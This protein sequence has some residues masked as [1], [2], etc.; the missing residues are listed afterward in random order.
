MPT[1]IAFHVL[2]ELD[3]GR[4]EALLRRAEADLSEY[5][6]A[7]TPI[8]EAVRE[9]GDVALRRYANEFD[10][11]D[12]S[13]TGLLVSSEEFDRAAEDVSPELA[14][15]L[16][17]AASNIRKFCSMQMPK[18]SRWETEMA[19]GVLVG[20]RLL[21]VD[22]AACYCPSGKG[23]FP[24]VALM[25]T[26]PALM[27]GVPEIVLLTPPGPDG[28]VDAGTLVAAR[29]AGVSKV[30]K[31]GGA[32]AVAAAAFGTES[33]PKCVKFEGPGN[34]W[35][36][37]ARR[38]LS[39]TIESRLPA[40]PS[41]T[42]LLADPSADPRLCALDL[43]IESEHGP[44]S[45]AFLVTWSAEV[46]RAARDAIPGFLANMGEQRRGYCESVLSGDSGGIVLAR[47]ADEAY[48][49][50][51]DYA[52]EHLQVMSKEPEGH[53]A[54][55]RNAAE[56][57]L[58]EWTPGSIA[59]YMMGP[60]CVLPTNGAARVHSPLSVRDFSKSCTIGML[61]ERGYALLAPHTRR[62]AE[63]EGFEGHAKAVSD[64]RQG[65][66]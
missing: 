6:D 52:P 45:S 1:Q 5:V 24:S 42:I 14:K 8:I 37:A 47:D 48:S 40:G 31:V 32:Q 4:R 38:V 61:D 62:F 39:G 12:L 59:N 65:D 30:A 28:S 46:A 20:E 50:V 34:P 26:I 43:L 54:H 10:G 29:I 56:I 27:A 25:T 9:E 44:D 22:S 49:F 15:T 7:V 36:A 21:P 19:P 64:A 3:V 18:E 58:G 60:N 11:A 2:A 57:L 16:E 13:G 35:L 41:E 51:N 66:S 33:V 17:L 63:Y 23:S 53:V 55:I